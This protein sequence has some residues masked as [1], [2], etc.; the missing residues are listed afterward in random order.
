MR[1]WW[2]Q[3]AHSHE[4]ALCHYLELHPRQRQLRQQ[5]PTRPAA[6][7]SSQGSR[8]RSRRIAHVRSARSI[9][10]RLPASPS[11]SCADSRGRRRLGAVTYG[12]LVRSVLCTPDAGAQILLHEADVVDVQR[13]CSPRTGR[14]PR[15]V[16]APQR[17]R[18][19]CGG[20]SRCMQR[21]RCPGPRPT[22]FAVAPAT[23][24]NG[25]D[26]LRSANVHQARF[27]LEAEAPEPG[28]S[29]RWRPGCASCGAGQ[30]E[31]VPLSL[32]LRTRNCV[33]GGSRRQI[34]HAFIWSASQGVS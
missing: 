31:H 32:P 19:G 34:T 16:S 24:G 7:S 9:P 22:H 10:R 11:G 8:S 21:S 12:G 6:P 25:L 14:V 3:S 20:P 17:A 1:S 28:L 15:P 5:L 33:G 18:R 30:A 26:T 27:R 2:Y 4:N 13:F 23:A 29:V